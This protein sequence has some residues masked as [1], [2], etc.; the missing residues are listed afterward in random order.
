[1]A[2]KFC[3]KCAIRYRKNLI[4]YRIWALIFSAAVFTLLIVILVNW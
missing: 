2:V 3:D 1:M 4:C